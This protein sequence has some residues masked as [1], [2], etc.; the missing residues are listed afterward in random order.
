MVKFLSILILTNFIILTICH[1][2]KN[3]PNRNVKCSPPKT[4]NTGFFLSEETAEDLFSYPTP[5]SWH[6]HVTYKETNKDEIATAKKILEKATLYF[7]DYLLPDNCDNL[8]DAGGLCN[9][10][11]GELDHTAGGPFPIGQWSWYVPNHHL[12]MI[13]NWF[14]T[15]REGLAVLFHP[16]TGCEF[17]DHSIWAMW[18]GEKW[19]LDTSI[20]VQDKQSAEFN[21]EVGDK[22]NP[23]C[24]AVNA[25][26]DVPLYKGPGTV[27][28]TGTY[29]K[30]DNT[31]VNCRCTALHLSNE[32]TE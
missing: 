8:F 20:F 12:P 13:V 14:I 17:E 3:F 7:K 24:A 32:E 4:K 6:V 11:D 9:I 10:Y 25:R 21:N 1:S 22:Q 30:C 28:C 15:N 31:E 2:P 27:C 16:N 19:N 23:T 26:C 18:V 5:L 29:C